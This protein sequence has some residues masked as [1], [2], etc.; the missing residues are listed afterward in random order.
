MLSTESYLLISIQAGVNVNESLEI[1]PVTYRIRSP[2]AE[3][4]R[5]TDEWKKKSPNSK[6]QNL[7]HE[8]FNDSQ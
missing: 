6:S 2:S 5:F 8:H 1:I 3:I 7:V 4:A